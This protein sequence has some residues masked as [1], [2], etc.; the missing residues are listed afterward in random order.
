MTDTEQTDQEGAFDVE[1]TDSE[2]EE[3]LEERHRR[4]SRSRP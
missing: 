4:K 3:A 2:A 1:I